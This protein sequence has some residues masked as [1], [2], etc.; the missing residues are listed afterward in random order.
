MQDHQ[1]NIGQHNSVTEMLPLEFP[2]AVPS[3][4]CAEHIPMSDHY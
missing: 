2:R 1:M 3:R 4:L